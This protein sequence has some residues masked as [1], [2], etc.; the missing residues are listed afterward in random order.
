MDAFLKTFSSSLKIVSI[1][2]NRQAK[3]GGTLYKK[4]I[5]ARDDLPVSDKKTILAFHGTADQNID[6]ICTNG[7]DESKRSRQYYGD[8]E[9]FATTPSKSLDYVKGGKRILL[10]ELLLGQ[11]GV[12][13]KMQGNIV[14]MK[15]SAHDLPRFII[16]FK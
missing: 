16:T 10:N 6:S 4:F 3:P 12:H 7:Y 5:K 15:N 9:Y 1:E 11:Q 14:V 8:G 13:H 2:E